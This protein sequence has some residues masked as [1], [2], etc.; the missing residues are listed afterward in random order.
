MLRAPPRPRDIQTA[1]CV[2]PATPGCWPLALSLLEV[3]NCSCSSW[4][5]CN[6]YRLNTCIHADGGMDYYGRSTGCILTAHWLY[7]ALNVH[8]PAQPEI[9]WKRPRSSRSRIHGSKSALESGRERTSGA[10][11]ANESQPLGIA[12]QQPDDSA[13]DPGYLA[14]RVD[15][16]LLTAP[17]SAVAKKGTSWSMGAP[18]GG[19][20]KELT[21]YI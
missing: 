3:Q 11:L 16:V 12:A 8:S 21:P 1:A 5:V 19:P 17:M 15:D 7:T 2:Y 18:N 10:G 9:F 4:A 13:N 14:A 6:Q 20:L